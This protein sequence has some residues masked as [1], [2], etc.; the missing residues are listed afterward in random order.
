MFDIAVVIVEFKENENLGLE[1]TACDFSK[2]F[3][4]VWEIL[5]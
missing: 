3:D 5:F 2:L 4:Y 1:F